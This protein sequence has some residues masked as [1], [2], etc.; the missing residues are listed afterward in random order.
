MLITT[1]IR[2]QGTADKVC[3]MKKR[4]INCTSPQ[5]CL[6][7]VRNV[8]FTVL[9]PTRDWEDSLSLTQIRDHH[10]HRRQHWWQVEKEWDRVK[11]ILSFVKRQMFV[12]C[13]FFYFFIFY[14][15]ID[16]AGVY[17]DWRVRRNAT[18]S[19]HRTDVNTSTKQA[20]T[21]IIT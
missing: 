17:S 18:Q 21:F 16:N 15:T 4:Q 5:G 13:W 20:S 7:I 2:P 14:F 12:C 19:C 10:T 1:T 8:R 3:K 9:H 6:N 11:K